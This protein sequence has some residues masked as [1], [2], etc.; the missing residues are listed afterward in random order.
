MTEDEWR[1]CL[2]RMDDNARSIEMWEPAE[3]DASALRCVDSR[4]RTLAHLRACQET[5]LTACAAFAERSEPRFSLP[6]PWRVFEHYG[7]ATIAWHDH[8]AAYVADRTRWKAILSTADRM[9]GGVVDGK[10]RTI[11]S[12][13]GRLV[14]HEKRHLIGPR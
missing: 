6:H 5:W 12:L 1:D 2:R 9:R 4:H 3:P 8:L 13:T 7:Y 14:A 10:P 11:A